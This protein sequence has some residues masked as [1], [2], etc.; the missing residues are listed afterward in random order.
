MRF[1]GKAV[2]LTAL[3]ALTFVGLAAN[4]RPA[5]AATVT[6]A[7]GDTYF[8]DPAHMGVQCVTAID[9]GDTVVWDF[10]SSANGHTT[11]SCGASC[12]TPDGA[13][14]DS[15]SIEGSS[16]PNTF[17]F[18]FDEPGV[19]DYVCTFHP[20]AQ[21][22]RIVVTELLF[23]DTNC[24]GN[25]NSIDAALVLQ[26]GAGL[27]DSLACQDNAD[28]NGDGIANSIDSALI[29]QFDAGLIDSLPV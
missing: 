8:C 12:D 4:T 2:L 27:V 22:G 15:G 18:T 9:V 10:A 26:L 19:Y 25:V 3:V 1:G 7:V 24:D 21:M 6:V 14:W 11:T 13:L 29:L 17:E 16:I 20:F 5:E 23:G 28:V